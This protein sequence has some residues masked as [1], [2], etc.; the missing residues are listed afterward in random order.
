MGSSLD[1]MWEVVRAPWMMSFRGHSISSETQI[2]CY[3]LDFGVND[4]ICLT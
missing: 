1:G 4:H 2:E 3:V